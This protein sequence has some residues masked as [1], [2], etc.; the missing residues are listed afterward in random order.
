MYDFP[1]WGSGSGTFLRQL[2]AKLAKHNYHVGVAAP[3][4]RRF[5]DQ[6]ERFII[7]PKQ[8]AVFVGHP[9]LR[10]AKL[11]SK[12]RNDEILEIYHGY[13]RTCLS[14]VKKFKP[15]IIHVNHL[16]IIS[17]VA[18]FLKSVTGVPYIITSHGSDLHCLEGDRR[19]RLLTLDALRGASKITVVSADTRAWLKRLFG[20]EHSVKLRTIPG[21]IDA[22]DIKLGFEKK[23]FEKKYHLGGKKVVLFTGRLTPQKGV[24]HLIKAA[25]HIPAEVFIIGDGPEKGS[26]QALVKEMGLANVH[27]VGYLGED[28][29]E[30]LRYFYSNCDVFVAPSVWDEPLGLVIL[31]AMAHEKPVV[32]TR[33][34]G[35]PL[36][37]KDG[38]NGIFV[39]PRNSREIAK[40][41]LKLL[42]NDKLKEEMGRRA[43]KTV[44]EK[45]LWEK[46][47]L[48][49]ERIYK[50]HA[51]N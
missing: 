5:H 29:S 42:S 20:D 10:E 12:L 51:L 11:Y 14:I 43:R 50:D 41:V 32:V 9:E 48:K 8:M 45:F 39:R 23:V 38:R 2:A 46:I 24:K 44:I 49:F 27:F 17:W 13:L 6:I 18:R 4:R 30:E 7:K 21:G 33:K 22:E 25:R 40:A 16:S 37:V 28:K 36:A 26:L 34:G 15:D 31:E 1:L 3:E 19:Y 35:I 47:A